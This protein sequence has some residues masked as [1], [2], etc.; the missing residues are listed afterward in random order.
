MRAGLKCH[1]RYYVYLV[2]CADGTYYAGSTN[3]L[4]RRLTLHNAGRGAKY[5]RGRGPVRLVYTKEYQ[6]YKQALD[7]ERQLKKFTRKQ[8][9][10]LIHVYQAQRQRT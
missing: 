1:A 9:E 8:K 7:A 4:E 5:L 6:Y 3:D 2:R 10:E